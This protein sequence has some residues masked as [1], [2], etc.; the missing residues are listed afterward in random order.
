MI[1]ITDLKTTF[2]TGLFKKHTINAVDVV[3]LHIKKGETLGLVGESGCG[4]TTLGK[5]ILRLVEPSAGTI[6][7]DNQDITRLSMR[8][9]RKIRP[10]MQMIF[11]DPDSSL[12]PRMTVAESIAEPLR[13]AG[14]KKQEIPKR[15]E[16]LLTLVGLSLEHL[17]RHPYELS[18][19]QNQRVVL[20][21]VLALEPDF[22]IADEP[23]SALDVS[24]QA[25]ILKLIRDLKDELGL[26]CLFISH[27]LM[28]VRHMSDSIAVMGQGKIVEI[29]TP[30]EIFE[31][32]SHPYTKD[33][34]S[35]A[36]NAVLPYK[37]ESK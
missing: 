9:M 22:I 36:K 28:V 5:T 25:Q 16:E 8:E 33:L 24:V 27:D 6:C 10:R 14:T 29:G 4:K 18:G 31:S 11:Q 21:R 3:S 35:F 32:P 23:T 20:A 13:Q 17:D 30:D 2:S 26:T 34:V 15:V 19:G 1:E 7:F 37:K 12:N